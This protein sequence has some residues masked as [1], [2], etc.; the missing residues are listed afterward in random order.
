LSAQDYLIQA[1]LILL[2]AGGI[3]GVRY[4]ILRY[5]KPRPGAGKAGAAKKKPAKR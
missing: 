5:E 2:A 1:G 3:F 4:L